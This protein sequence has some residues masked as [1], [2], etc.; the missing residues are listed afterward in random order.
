MKARAK[1]VLLI[2]TGWMLVVL[3]VV[4][5]IVP[6]LHGTVFMIVGLILLSK[7][8]VWADEL[9][10]KVRVKFPRMSAFVDRCHVSLSARWERLW[11]TP[12]VSD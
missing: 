9:L 4:G 8:Y 11:G 6:I 5:W 3:G 10:K 12:E 2:A 7:E 1:R